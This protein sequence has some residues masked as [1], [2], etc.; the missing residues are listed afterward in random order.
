MRS[1]PV[2]FTANLTTSTIAKKAREKLPKALD[3]GKK[4]GFAVTPGMDV[5][6]FVLAIFHVIMVIVL[7]RVNI[8]EL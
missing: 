2:I 3:I 5:I 4:L 7:T 1:F 8:R 6:R